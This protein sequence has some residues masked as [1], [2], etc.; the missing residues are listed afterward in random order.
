MSSQTRVA[1]LYDIHAKVPALDAVLAEVERAGV[2][3]IM[4][5]GVLPAPLPGETIER[6]RARLKR[7][8][9]LEPATFGLGSRR[10]TC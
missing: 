4:V 9:G 3:R 5:G 8:T 2:D 10:S 1:A 7:T 6:L